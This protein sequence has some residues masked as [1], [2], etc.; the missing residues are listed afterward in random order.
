MK[1]FKRKFIALF[2]ILTLASCTAQ[3][4]SQK[5]SDK[6]WNTNYT[7]VFVH[8][9]AGWGHYDTINKFFP[10]WGLKTGSLMKFLKKNGFTT[11]D[12]SVSPQGSA[13]DRACEL[14]AQL[15]GSVTDYGIEHSTRCNHARFGTDFSKKPLIKQ[16]DSEKKINLI[17]HSFGGA[18][19]RLFSQLMQ[20]GSQE[21]INA[22]PED[23]LSPFFKGGHT[24]WIYSITTLAS[25]HNG[26]SAYHIKDPN[27]ELRTKKQAMMDKVSAPF[28]DKRIA[29]DAASFDMNLNNAKVL[30]SKIKT[31]EHI[32]YFSYACTASI[33]QPDGTYHPDPDKMEEMFQRKS[34]LMG[35]YEG[36]AHDNVILTKD[37]QQNDG[38]VN[39]IS[40]L[41]PFEAPSKQ[42]DSSNIQPGI[43][44]IMPVYYGDHMS[45][46]G[47]F[48][49][50]NE[51]KDFYLQH[52]NRINKLKK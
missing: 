16:W 12:A 6:E 13:W 20:E 38:L 28:K 31:F 45:L 43:W 7:Y 40:A 37:W 11:V 46:Q 36:P 48:T 51:V 52:L 15:T 4:K 8:G 25:P 49:I 3:T 24:D 32:Y 5:L 42:F 18:T 34:L 1:R 21:E 14:Y 17:G 44:N 29:S 2:S 23:Q 47:G 19:I 39:T 22:T 27:P 9:L 10:Y 41:A 30:N 33:K 50:K 26:T 35:T